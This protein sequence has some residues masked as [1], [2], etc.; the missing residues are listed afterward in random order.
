MIRLSIFVTTATV[1]A[2]VA[3]TAALAQDYGNRPLRYGNTS[4]WN[5]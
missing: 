3:I 2:F 1:L 5:L 4:G